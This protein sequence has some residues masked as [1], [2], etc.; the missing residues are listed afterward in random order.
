LLNPATNEA[1]V[2]T[3][4]T[5]RKYPVALAEAFQLAVI[6]EQ[7][8]PVPAVAAGT[9]GV[10]GLTVTASVLAALVPQLLPAVTVILPFC[11]AAPVV[12]VAEMVPCPAVIVHP[13]GTAHV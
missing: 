1:K 4:E 6:W 5:S 12:T 2:F 7:V 10:P 9:G 13:A 11:P 3:V 8:A